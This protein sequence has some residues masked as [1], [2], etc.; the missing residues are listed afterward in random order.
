MFKDAVLETQI[1]NFMIC[2]ECDEHV[3]LRESNSILAEPS[4]ENQW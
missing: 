2:V 4:S 1:S 3:S